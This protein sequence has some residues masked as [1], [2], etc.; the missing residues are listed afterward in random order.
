MVIE[1]R[2]RQ[3]SRTQVF[4]DLQ[5][6][7]LIPEPVKFELSLSV[8]VTKWTKTRFLATGDCITSLLRLQ[9]GHPEF[10]TWEVFVGQA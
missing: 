10:S 5:S 2:V 8:P 4:S 6:A 9:E 3:Y 7:P 1:P